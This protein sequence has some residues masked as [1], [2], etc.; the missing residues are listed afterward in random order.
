MDDERRELPEGWV[1]CWDP[2]N[3]HHFYVD[4]ATKRSTWLH[5]YD[6]PEFLRTLPEHHPAHPNSAEATAMRKRGEDEA[7]LVQKARSHS[8]SQPGPSSPPKGA[9]AGATNPDGS[10][11]WPQHEEHRNW[12]QRKKD[13]LIGTKEE[14][15]KAKEDRRKAKAE[16]LRKRREME[17]QYLK[18]RQELMRQQLNDPNI[19]NYYASDPFMYSAPAGPY[20]RAGGLYASPYGYG[21][22]G[23]Y[24]RR[25]GYG[26]GSPYGYGYGPGGLGM[27]GGLMLG[28]GAGLLGGMLLGDALAGG[29]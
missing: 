20:S 10:H 23:G 25:Y 3:E 26:Y 13:K 18:R 16:A 15:A 17:E 9:G 29:F 1:R 2:K 5:P 12:I 14:R 6:D 4:T 8:S 7:L 24:G 11:A 22:P 28:G 19:R 21:Y 27:G